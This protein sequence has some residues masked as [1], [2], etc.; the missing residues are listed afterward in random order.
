[1]MMSFG[2]V[3]TK[4]WFQSLRSRSQL[5]KPV[6]IKTWELPKVGVSKCSG[7]P[8]PNAPLPGGLVPKLGPTWLRSIRGEK[9][10]SPIAPPL[11]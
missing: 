4:P 9:C 10:P 8:L 11:P 6:Q 2:F 7:K 5:P 3:G 1:M